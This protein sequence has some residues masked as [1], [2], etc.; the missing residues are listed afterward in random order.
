MKLL[1]ARRLNLDCSGTKLHPRRNCDILTH[2]DTCLRKGPLPFG[3]PRLARRQRKPARLP[4]RSGLS[5]FARR[6]AGS[7]S[8]AQTFCVI[9]TRPEPPSAIKLRAPDNG[10]SERFGEYIEARITAGISRSQPGARSRC[11]WLRSLHARL[12]RLCLGGRFPFRPALADGRRS[13]GTSSSGGESSGGGER[14]G[15][16]S[17][18][19]GGGSGGGY[20][21]SGGGDGGGQRG[22]NG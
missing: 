18:G 14:E 20:S 3:L 1:E 9:C 11:S 21:G 6:L 8:T 16:G 13:G 17:G 12:S 10:I 7:K 15:G 19:G 2:K 5:H 22:G 4:C